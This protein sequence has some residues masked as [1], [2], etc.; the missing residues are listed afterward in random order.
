MRGTFLIL[1]F[2]FGHIIWYGINVG[3][4]SHN[5]EVSVFE[6]Y[7]LCNCKEQLNVRSYFY[8][9]LS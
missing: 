1:R 7:I 8:Y 5:K 9:K 4:F 3:F 2:F 6:E